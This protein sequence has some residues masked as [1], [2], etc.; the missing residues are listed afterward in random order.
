MTI[1]TWTFAA[2]SIEYGQVQ[3]WLQDNILFLQRGYFFKDAKGNNINFGHNPVDNNSIILS[4]DWIDV[5]EN[6]RAALAELDA[7]SVQKIK[8]KEGI[9]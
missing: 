5:P 2:E 7:Y 1:K 3:I 9:V 4:M 8:E 6:I